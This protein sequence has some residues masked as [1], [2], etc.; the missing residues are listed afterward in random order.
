MSQ[1]EESDFNSTKH[2]PL[3]VE[4][5]MKIQEE[6]KIAWENV[7]WRDLTKPLYSGLAASLVLRT[8]VGDNTPGVLEKQAEYWMNNYH[9][10]KSPD[11]FIS[12]IQ[13]IP[14]GKCISK[15]VE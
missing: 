14:V 6:L 3:L 8:K 11:Y 4:Q 10:D 5:Y 12:Q 2:N 9:A 7:R 1:V 15:I 13:N